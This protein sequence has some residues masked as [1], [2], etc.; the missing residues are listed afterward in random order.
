MNPYLN[1]VEN[2]L[3]NVESAKGLTV[4]EKTTPVESEDKVLLFS[5]HPDD[6]CITGLLAL[7]LMREAGMQIINVPVTYGSNVE[8]QSARAA[9]LKDACDYL[10]WK[11]L[12]RDGFQALEKDDIVEILKQEQ[13]KVVFFPHSKDWN[14]RHIS[15]HFLVID[16]LAQMPADFSCPVVEVEFWAAMA[17]PNLMVEA[18][19][20][21]VADLA[22]RTGGGQGAG[23]VL[24]RAVF[25]WCFAGGRPSSIMR[26]AS[27]N[28]PSCL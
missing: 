25:S 7:R 21:S 14:S 12:E 6:E 20:Q 5:P 1:Y 28:L 2:I 13:P 19:A 26:S 17:D 10:G 23:E 24:E 15:T 8:R 18:D 9:E 22:R 4:D 16:A 3:A 11:I 27:S